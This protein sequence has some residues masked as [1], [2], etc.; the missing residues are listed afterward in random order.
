MY[1]STF[2]TLADMSTVRTNK[3]YMHSLL[4]CDLQQGKLPLLVYLTFNLKGV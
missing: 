2:F 1:T 4:A 3:S